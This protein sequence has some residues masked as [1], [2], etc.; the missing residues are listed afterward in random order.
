MKLGELKTLENERVSW[1]YIEEVK[2]GVAHPI[3]PV[4]AGVMWIMRL[5]QVRV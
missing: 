3:E 2:G 1:T 5:S 4:C